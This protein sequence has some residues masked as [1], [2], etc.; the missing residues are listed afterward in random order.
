MT[1]GAVSARPKPAPFVVDGTIK[2]VA[3]GLRSAPHYCGMLRVRQPDHSFKW[4]F[5]VAP[6]H[7]ARSIVR[8][9]IHNYE[10]VR[11]IGVLSTGF[12]LADDG[13]P[14]PDFDGTV[15]D[16]TNVVRQP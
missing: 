3:R 8:D 12:S 11:V 5:V 15:I 7:V 13:P 6:G 10:P 16:A 9:R 14:L 1:A 4:Y 2:W